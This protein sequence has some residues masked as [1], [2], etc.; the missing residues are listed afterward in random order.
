MFG[1]GRQSE[2]EGKREGKKRET[3]HGGGGGKKRKNFLFLPEDELARQRA[4]QRHARDREVDVRRQ[5]PA[6]VREVHDADGGLGEADDEEV[7]GVGEEADAGD[8]DGLRLCFF[9]LR[10]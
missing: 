2:R 7:V 3:A 5:L 4:D 1:F 9:V 6:V 8:E 10:G